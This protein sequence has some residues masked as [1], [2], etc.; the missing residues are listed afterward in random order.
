MVIPPPNEYEI[1]V[2]EPVQLAPPNA[3]RDERIK[4][5]LSTPPK[6]CGC[7]LVNHGWNKKCYCGRIW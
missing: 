1:P 4:R 7:G 2:K 5:F 3:E 6:H